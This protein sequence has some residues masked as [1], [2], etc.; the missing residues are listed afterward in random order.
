[1]TSFHHNLYNL[2]MLGKELY[3]YLCFRS[4]PIICINS[5]F[6]CCI[7]KYEVNMFKPNITGLIESIHKTTSE[8]KILNKPVSALEYM[9][10]GSF[11]FDQLH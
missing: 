4:Y 10:F 7:L 5:L 6:V 11:Q 1:M 3:K 8:L 9:L 2:T